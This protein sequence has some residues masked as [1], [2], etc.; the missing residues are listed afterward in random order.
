MDRGT[1]RATV[2]GVVKSRTRLSAHAAPAGSGD[3]GAGV[4]VGL[5]NYL[6]F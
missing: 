5:Y 1:W 3:A 2:N 4:H 6:N